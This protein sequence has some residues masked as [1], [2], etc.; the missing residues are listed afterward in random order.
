MKVLAGLMAILLMAC[1]LMSSAASAE[2]GDDPARLLGE[3]ETLLKRAHSQTNLEKAA[4][5]YQQA[6][7]TYR[8][9]NDLENTG[10]THRKLGLL[11]QNWGQYK[12]A[13]DHYEKALEIYR[14]LGDLRKEGAVLNGLGLMYAASGKYEKAISSYEGALE[15][16]E[17]LS[18]PKAKANT[19]NDLGIVYAAQ[20]Q[21]ERAVELY[22]SSLEITRKLLDI[23]GEAYTHGNL[24][25]VYMDWKQ[26]DKA[27][28]HYEKTL[29]IARKMGDRVSEAKALGNLGNVYQEC[30]RYQKAVSVYEESLAIAKLVGNLAIEASAL[31]NMG[32]IYWNWGEYDKAI[33]SFETNLE[34]RKK[35]GDTSGEAYILGNLGNVYADWGQ[36]DK[37]AELYH[38]T[39]AIAD[40][41][42]DP[43]AAMKALG[44]LGQIF[45][46]QGDTNKARTNF[47]KSLA[48]CRKIGVSDR[49]PKRLMADM[50]LDRCALDEA[51]PWVRQV[52]SDS[53]WG[54]FWLMKG[55]FAQ[56]KTHYTKMV[57]SAQE[58]R[59]AATLFAGYTGLGTAEEGS[60]DLVAAMKSF[61]K[62]VSIC[63]DLRSTL[64]VAQR[65]TFFDVRVFGFYRTAA[66]EGLARVLL[67]MDR[68]DRA[69]TRSEHTKARIFSE[70][71][72]R[73]LRGSGV[74]VPA[75]VLKTASELNDRVAAL[76]AARNRAVQKNSKQSIAAI[77]PQIQ[78]KEQ[79]L[80]EHVKMVREKY[81]LFA[82]TMYPEPM[83]LSQT[84]LAEDEW[85]LAYD[86]TDSG[87]IVYLC[88]GKEL[89]KA[90]FK[91]IDRKDLDDL[92]RTFR[93]PLEVK[94]GD[95]LEQ[96]LASFDLVSGRKL[97]NILLADI[98]QDLPKNVPVIVA[99]D[100]AL[101]VLPFEML[102]LGHQGSVSS[103]DGIPQTV[104]VTFFGD[105]NPLSYC[106]SLTALTLSRTFKKEKTSADKIMVIADPIFSRDDPRVKAKIAAQGQGSEP[107]FTQEVLMSAAAQQD[108]TWPR[109][110][111]TRELGEALKQTYPDATELYE[112]WDAGKAAITAKD[113]TP[114]QAIIFA[115]HGYAADDL[116][117]LKEPVLV[118]TLIDQPADRDGF[119]RLSEVMGL[120]LRADIVALT[121]CQ[122]G[123]GKRITGEG[124]M[125]MGRAFQ[126]AGARSVLMSLWSVAEEPSMKLVE[127]FF[128]YMKQGKGK[129]EALKMARDDIRKAGY[130][131]PFF[132][133]SFILVGDTP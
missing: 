57:A 59:D 52:D 48:I 102:V 19:L 61:E 75:D 105:R 38:K 55:D 97:S 95:K 8:A 91:P 68:P 98:L 6:L 88:K 32:V 66:Y 103:G 120:D 118:L 130:D 40:K 112:G 13:L 128:M 67:K 39:L 119:L 23:R 70:S 22:Q 56:A 131:H 74:T 62:A 31:N 85:G 41:I 3:A 2:S 16:A 33:R 54:R 26:Y 76:K 109:L 115:T 92:V 5:K 30:G 73:R 24:G 49:W 64:T 107:K 81:P 60:G 110:P 72:S 65:E 34:I 35:V 78:K 53:T 11:Y 86:V 51:E 69:F 133:A 25:N 82:A 21:Y 111:K 127:S 123:L 94:A 27:T 80:A 47:E 42:G 129:L 10:L 101:T 18:A 106:Q 104:D 46:F 15:L 124:T 122:S 79:M 20:G 87:V 117:G 132:W 7:D 126:Y 114:Y 113:L 50:Y 83:A 116:G 1:S 71:V 63:E 36:Y 14:T 37:A 99:P 12:K 77:E 44:K 96:K 29:G 108:I 121:A 58:N 4:I 125:G 84:A 17:T 9:Q 28:D 43:Q 100:D 45:A 89:K 90:L 93:A